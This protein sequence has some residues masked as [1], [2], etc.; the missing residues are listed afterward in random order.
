MTPDLPPPHVEIHG[1]FRLQ[2][3]TE[4]GADLRL[5]AHP[6][7]HAGQELH[8]HAIGDLRATTA[9]PDLVGV[10]VA[11]WGIAE[12]PIG[13]ITAGRLPI[14]LWGLGLVANPG[15]CLN[16]VSDFTVDR[17]SFATEVLGHVIGVAGDLDSE[18]IV[19]GTLSI[20]R[21]PTDLQRVRFLDADKSIWG[22]G[23]WST[24]RTRSRDGLA[25]G[26]ADG[27]IRY[28]LGDFRIEGEG[29]F[30]GGRIQR[31][32]SGDPNLLLPAI[33]VQQGGGAL[34][35]ELSFVGLQGGFASGDV[36]PG[37]GG[38]DGTDQVDPPNDTAWTNFTIS[39]NYFIDRLQWR[40]RIGRITDVAWVRPALTVAPVEGLKLQAWFTA[41][42]PIVRTDEPLSPEVGGTVEWHAWK[43]FQ[44]RSDVGYLVGDGAFLQGYLAWV[45]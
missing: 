22:Y 19:T 4:A 32:E 30:A 24:W 38:V 18:Q 37:R 29:V 41:S 14:P 45:Y 15:G 39:D 12:T 6:E 27:W 16:C 43:G 1:D 26:L 21:L 23:V 33:Y 5:R 2:A 7:F 28:E 42:T 10:P 3:D 11:A 40:R 44:L 35:A 34:Q 36:A 31:P 13:E 17:V 8:V 9:G 25:I 20:A